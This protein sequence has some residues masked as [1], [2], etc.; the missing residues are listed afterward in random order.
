[1]AAEAFTS[2]RASP[3]E[4]YLWRCSTPGCRMLLATIEGDRVRVRIRTRHGMRDMRFLAAG[5]QQRCDECGH[6]N[7]FDVDRRPAM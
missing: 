5:S 7:M 6:V 4:R 2:M 1:M 3:D